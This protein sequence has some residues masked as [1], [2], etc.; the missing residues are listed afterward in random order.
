MG[1]RNSNRHAGREV[2]FLDRT[3]RNPWPSRFSGAGINPGI[4][5]KRKVASDS[6]ATDSVESGSRKTRGRINP[7][8]TRPACR[9]EF[10]AHD[11]GTP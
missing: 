3:L 6:L 9:L 5:K 11:R 7:A 8:Q 4:P 10:R 2:V 1:T